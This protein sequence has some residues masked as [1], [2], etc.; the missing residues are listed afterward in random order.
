M[1][2]F[3]PED[4]VSEIRNTANIVDI[5]SEVVLLKKAGK[6]YLGLC[7]FHSEKTPSFT[8]SPEKQIFFCF[9]CAAGGNVFSFLMKHEGL[10]FPESV[11]RLANRYGIELPLRKMSPQQKQR[12]N[13]KESILAVNRLAL[14]FFRRG[15]ANDGLG[16]AARSYLHQRGMVAEVLD[17]FSLGYAPESWD[18]LTRFLSTKKISQPLAEKSGLIVPRRNKSGFYDRFRNRIMFP[19]FDVNSQVIGFGGRVLDDSEPKYLNSPETPVYNK[20]RSLY[21]IHRA[22]KTCRERGTV[23]IVE[24]YF[25]LLTLHQH[26]LENAV[27]TLG[28]A[29]T[30]EH[31]RF[32]KGYVTNVVLVYDSD[33]AGIKAALRSIETFMKEEMDARIMVLPTGHDPDSFLLKF[34]AHAFLKIASEA[35]SVITF[36]IESAI[37]KHGLSIEGKIRVVRDLL[38]PLSAVSDSVARSLY[39]KELSERIGIDEIAIMEKIRKTSS[40]RNPGFQKDRWP[41]PGGARHTADI[42]TSD[43]MQGASPHSKW[44][45]MERQIIS[46]MLQY[47]EIVSEIRK[48]NILALFENEDMKSIGQLVLLSSGSS[49]DRVSDIISLTDDPQMKNN[50]AQLAIGEDL[51]EREKCLNILARFESGHKRGEKK[52][53][54]QIKKAEENNDVERLQQLLKEKQKEA[55]SIEKQKMMLLK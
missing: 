55:V 54:E 40:P 19:I 50:I 8:V 32:L 48:R 10:S 36:L 52:L 35:R 30:P 17:N 16:K 42:S 7:P 12:I 9:G 21:G 33:E 18:F 37:K 38:A 27:A 29:L 4:K 31:V 14:D 24:G 15:L 23:Y 25:D 22:K 2:T 49:D 11:K 43:R 41:G 13:E 39:I 28:T 51:W 6:N 1:A 53:I 44:G 34:G 20:R 3:I 26:G 5:V 45:R 46:M 47:P